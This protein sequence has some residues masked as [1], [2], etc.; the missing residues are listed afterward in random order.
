MK[1]SVPG[2]TKLKALSTSYLNAQPLKRFGEFLATYV[3]KRGG[4]N[5]A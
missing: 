2:A 3:L 4:K 5:L 1:T